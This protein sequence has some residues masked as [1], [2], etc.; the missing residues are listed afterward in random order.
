M[1]SKMTSK[2]RTGILF[3][4]GFVPYTPRSLT[5][6]MYIVVVFI[7]CVCMHARRQRARACPQ[8]LIY[9]F[10]VTDFVSGDSETPYRN[11]Y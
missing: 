11:R 8:L 1:T 4:V 2:L 6:V 3:Y 5:I 10:E 7:I 9:L